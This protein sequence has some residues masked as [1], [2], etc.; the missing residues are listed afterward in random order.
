M[1]TPDPSPEPGWTALRVL[2]LIFGLLVLTG[3]GI[4]GLCGIALGQTDFDILLLGLAGLV[5]AFG[6]LAL[7]VVII[8]RAN[9]TAARSRQ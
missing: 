3:F 6:G 9:G 1:S 7:I 2:G 8:R 4:C 5:I